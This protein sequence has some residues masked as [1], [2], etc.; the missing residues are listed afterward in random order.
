MS[1]K[2]E[3]QSVRQCQC[4]KAKSAPKAWLWLK[5]QIKTAVRDYLEW[6]KKVQQ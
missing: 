1:D 4:Q 3:R 6:A 2:N 5:K